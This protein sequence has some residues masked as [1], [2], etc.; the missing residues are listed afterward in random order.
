MYLIKA[1]TAVFAFLSIKAVSLIGACGGV[2]RLDT[3]IP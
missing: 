1:A 3:T 2:S